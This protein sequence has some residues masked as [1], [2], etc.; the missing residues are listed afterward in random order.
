LHR[1]HARRETERVVKTHHTSTAIRYKFAVNVRQLARQLSADY[2]VDA[3]HKG[4]CKSL[5]INW[6]ML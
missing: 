4:Y 3:I 2:E 1:S 6:E 5:P